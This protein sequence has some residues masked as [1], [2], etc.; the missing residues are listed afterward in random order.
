MF[1]RIVEILLLAVCVATGMAWAAESSFIG[2]WKLD[3]S[4]SRLPDEMKIQS[5]GGNKY[6]FDFGGAIETI[7]VGGSDQPGYGGTLLSVKAEGADTWVVQRKKDGRLL[8]TAT[9]KLAK[10]GNTLTD[11]FRG[12]DRSSSITKDRPPP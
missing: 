12:S 9:W 6:A 1:K 7:V 3:A 11:F 2:I 8:L 10:D 5:K 4:K